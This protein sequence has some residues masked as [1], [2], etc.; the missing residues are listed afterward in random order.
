VAQKQTH[1]SSKT[2]SW[3]ETKRK[4]LL[5]LGNKLLKGSWV[6]DGVTGWWALRRAHDVMRALG[7]TCNWWKS[8]NST[9]ETKKKV[10]FVKKITIYETPLCINYCKQQ[11]SLKFTDKSINSIC[12]IFPKDTYYVTLRNQSNIASHKVHQQYVIFSDEFRKEYLFCSNLMHNLNF[13]DK[14]HTNP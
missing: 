10:C 8:L 6:R 1:R 14:N 11:Y 12:S 7:V 13:N 9:S 2:K 5:T 3:W 4:R